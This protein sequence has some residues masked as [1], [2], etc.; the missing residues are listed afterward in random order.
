M[1][2]KGFAPGISRAKDL[3]GDLILVF[4]VLPGAVDVGHIAPADTLQ[5]EILAEHC[6]F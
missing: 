1:G 5:Q 2:A 3:D 6:A 4:V